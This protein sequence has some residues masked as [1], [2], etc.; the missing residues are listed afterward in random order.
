M[1]TNTWNG[2]SADWNTPADWSLGRVPGPTDDVVINSGEAQLGSSDPAIEVASISVTGGILALQDTGKTES[3]SGNVSLT[4]GGVVQLDGAY[5][6]GSGGSSLTIGGNLTNSST[7]GYGLDIG[8]TGIS[9][10]DTV[11]VNGAGGLS[12]T[13]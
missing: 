4:G 3:V 13:G 5:T 6:G 9:S 7:N 1:P 8:N 11:T 2:S 12:N 10:A